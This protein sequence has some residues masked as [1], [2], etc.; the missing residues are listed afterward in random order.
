MVPVLERLKTYEQFSERELRR[1][2][3]PRLWSSWARDVLPRAIGEDWAS[4][5][6]QAARHLAVAWIF[7]VYLRASPALRPGGWTF[8]PPPHPTAGG[9]VE[10]PSSPGPLQNQPWWLRKPGSL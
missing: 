2:K 7:K 5:T 9:E 3:E 10:S 1:R 4:G 8:R 6:G